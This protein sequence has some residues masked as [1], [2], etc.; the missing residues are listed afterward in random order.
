M[1]GVPSMPRFAGSDYQ[2]MRDDA[3]L[4]GQMLRV[5]ELMRHGAWMSLR[6][7]AKRTGDP[8]ASISAQLRFL[9]RPRFGG[10]TV[11]KSRDFAGLYLYRVKPNDEARVR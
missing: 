6:D 10:H 11:E 3:R 2:P 7:I 1:A 4:T 5:W 9:R 8:E